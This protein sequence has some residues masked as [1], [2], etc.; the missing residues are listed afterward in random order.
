MERRPSVVFPLADLALDMGMMERSGRILTKAAMDLL[1]S[2]GHVRE[3]TS[4]TYQLALEENLVDGVLQLTSS[5]T[6]YV[7]PGGGADDVFI[8]E[9]DLGVAF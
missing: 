6:G 9:S 4:E 5:G 3:I 8:K 7:V 1:I 2:G